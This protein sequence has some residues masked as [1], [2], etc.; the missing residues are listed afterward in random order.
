LDFFW[1]P[2]IPQSLNVAKSAS[3]SNDFCE[4]I[5]KRPFERFT[6][7]FQIFQWCKISHH[8][9]MLM[10]LILVAKWQIFATK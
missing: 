10:G 5:P 7:H 4:K 1:L 8:K 2:L 6:T 9:K 3:L